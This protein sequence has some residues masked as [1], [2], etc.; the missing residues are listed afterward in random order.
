MKMGRK[1][2]K[3][4]RLCHLSNR[5]AAKG[6][7]EARGSGVWGGMGEQNKNYTLGLDLLSGQ[8]ERK[9]TFWAVLVKQT[10]EQRKGAFWGVPLACQ[11]ERGPR[12]DQTTN[13]Y[14]PPHL[15][16]PPQLNPAPSMDIM[17]RDCSV[18]I[19]RA[20]SWHKK[21]IIHD[22]GYA[23]LSNRVVCVCVC[24]GGGI[25]WKSYWGFSSFCQDRKKGKE[26]WGCPSCQAERDR[27]KGNL[28]IEVYLWSVKQ[29]ERTKPLF[30]LPPPT[31]QP[32][33]IPPPSPFHW[34][35]GQRLFCSYVPVSYTHLTLPTRRTV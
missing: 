34:Y 30:P 26:F 6:W 20:V 15:H 5:K 25:K 14:S 4:V 13:R 23:F 9:V 12:L 29:R 17:A 32:P 22:S 10:Q 3:Y 28:H 2:S 31:T 8:E 35:N 1:A 33:L 21:T 19:Y 27:N 18:H 24:V 11:V 7:K 16:P